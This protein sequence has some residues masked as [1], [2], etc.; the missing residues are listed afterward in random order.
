MNNEHRVLTQDELWAEAR[1]RFGRHSADWAFQCPS[2]GDVATGHDIRQALLD[3]PRQAEGLSRNTEYTEVLG[4]ECI[5]RVLGKTAGRG[6]QYAAFG[7]I[8]G[9]WQ[10]AVP[11]RRKP[12]Y[13]FPLAP[14]P[15]GER[16]AGR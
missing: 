6:C 14:A 8:H 3:H 10:V 4:Q 15:A 16:E 5:G 9:P 11:H 12:M 2:C 13:C 1:E 7:F